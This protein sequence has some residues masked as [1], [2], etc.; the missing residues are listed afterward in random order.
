M[1]NIKHLVRTATEQLQGKSSQELQKNISPLIRAQYNDA[2]SV[3]VGC[4]TNE[5]AISNLARIKAAFPALPAPFFEILSARIIDNDFCDQ[6]LNDA[7]NHVIDTCKYPT[8]SIAE[9]ISFDRTF[10]IYTY[11]EI[12]KKA[13]EFGQ[14]VW[15]NYKAV[16]FRGRPKKVWVH[17]NDI[18]LYGLKDEE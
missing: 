1:E 12:M 7:V 8:P 17:V 18:E 6:R 16:K 3:Y 4:L 5:I 9:F 13:N 2:A 10:K 11:E 15:N 14:E